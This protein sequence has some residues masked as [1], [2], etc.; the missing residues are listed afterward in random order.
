MNLATQK[1]DE[2]STGDRACSVALGRLLSL[3][4][5]FQEFEVYCTAQLFSGY[6]PPS[7]ASSN[8]AM[9]HF[10]SLSLFLVAY[11]DRLVGFELPAKD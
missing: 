7:I 2:K 4:E 8:I 9:N 10:H 5:R 6:G 3:V 11:I 1:L